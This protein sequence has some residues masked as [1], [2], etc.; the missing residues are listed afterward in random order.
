[1]TNTS[2]NTGTTTNPSPTNP[3]NPT[4][5]TGPTRTSQTLNGFGGGTVVVVTRGSGGDGASLGS[6][7]A[8]L[9]NLSLGTTVSIT[10]DAVNNQARGT[11]VIPEL[12]GSRRHTPA[13]ATLEL[14][15]SAFVDDQTYSM[16]TQT[17]DPSRRSSL[18]RGTTT[19][20]LNDN[21]LLTSAN[22]AGLTLPSNGGCTCEFLTWGKWATSFTDPQNSNKTYYSL[23]LYVAGNLTTAVQMPTTGSATYNG[24]MAGLVNDRGSGRFGTGTFQLNYNFGARNGAFNGN[25]DSKALSGP[26]NASAANP[27]SYSGRISGGG[28]SGTA[29]GGFAGSPTDPLA[30]TLGNFSLRGPQYRASGIFAGQR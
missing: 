7:S 16:V 27:Q 26:M 23:G 1:M 24:F 30:Y 3:T 15:G 22:V 5:P 28:V 13:T 12:N 10:T 2:T 11:I 4:T 20:P 25:F 6:S 19:Q 29:N 18:Q 17:N 8:R 21:T 9:R 14:G